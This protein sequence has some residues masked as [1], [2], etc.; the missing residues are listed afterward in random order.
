MESLPS[1]FS[2]TAPGKVILHGD[3]SVVY[4]HL[5]MAASLDLKTK[6][7]YSLQGA[8]GSNQRFIHFVMPKIA[9]D[10]SLSLSEFNHLLSLTDGDTWAF[11]NPQ[12]IGSAKFNKILENIDSFMA[13]KPG[14][15]SLS[16]QQQQAMKCCLFLMTAILNHPKQDT[17]PRMQPFQLTVTSELPVGGGAG[18]SAS[19]CVSLAAL[20]V[21]I[22][23]LRAEPA[24]KFNLSDDKKEIISNWAFL[25]EKITH[26]NPS[27]L[28][29][30]VC[31][32]GSL[33]AFQ[34]PNTM[35]KIPLN[36]GLRVLLVDTKVSRNTKSLVERVA[37]LRQRHEPV[38]D[39]IMKAMNGLSLEA[40]ELLKQLDEAKLNKSENEV[41]DLFSKLEELW[42]I[43]H[44]LLQSL[45]VSHPSLERILQ[46]AREHNLSGK[47]TGAGGGGFAI[48]L[49]PGHSTGCN[50]ESMMENLL[51][52]GFDVRDVELGGPGVQLHLN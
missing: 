32:F 15:K 6:I 21:V 17:L 43:N 28:D 51:S 1:K 46:I 33:I 16:V 39:T 52:N 10:L 44:C 11:N 19:F 25:G 24:N 48:I 34:R 37:R 50:L 45:G 49:L 31:T 13:M 18:S 3:H 4:G 38:V 23:S 27:G 30:T 26:G 36:Q 41:A 12:S 9:L 40:K 35:E 29:N 2:I 14:L 47:L 7:E 20:F 8:A 5:A 42:S 22:A